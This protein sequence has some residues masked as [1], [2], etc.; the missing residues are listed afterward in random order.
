MNRYLINRIEVHDRQFAVGARTASDAVQLVLGDT[1]LETDEYV[2]EIPDGLIWRETDLTRGSTV[3]ELTDDPAL[4]D[5]LKACCEA[6]DDEYIVHGISRVEL[7]KP[8]S[9][10]FVKLDAKQIGKTLRMLAAIADAYDNNDVSD[11]L[12][13][14]P[15]GER[16]QLITIQDCLDAREALMELDRQVA[17]HS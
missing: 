17:S 11:I 16:K 14:T 12:L 7:V 5:D 2:Q 4:Q 10:D 9:R 15:Q 13:V 8:P 3:D 1:S 6:G